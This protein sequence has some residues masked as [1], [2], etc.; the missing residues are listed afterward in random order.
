M[1]N[2]ATAHSFDI[3]STVVEID[4]PTIRLS[5]AVTWRWYITFFSQHAPVLACI[6]LRFIL[7]VN[8]PFYE[9]LEETILLDRRTR[10]PT[11]SEAFEKEM[12]RDDSL[13]ARSGIFSTLFPFDL[14][15]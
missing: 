10:I 3:P 14:H 5:V 13:T 8:D 7:C 1:V 2:E 15:E 9:T 11:E 4:L 12:Q 6:H